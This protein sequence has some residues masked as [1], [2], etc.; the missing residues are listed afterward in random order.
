MAIA[1]V[2][3]RIAAH[4]TANNREGSFIMSF[5]ASGVHLVVSP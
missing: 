5:N 1:V 2:K 4:N 3:F